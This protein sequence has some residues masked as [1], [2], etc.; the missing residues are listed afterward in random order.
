MFG[1][2]ASGTVQGSM[3]KFG[4]APLPGEVVVGFYRGTLEGV[5]I[6][7]VHGENPLASRILNEPS[8]YAPEVLG[9]KFA[10]FALAMREYTRHLLTPGA[11]PDETLPDGVHI[12]D[13][14]PLPAFLCIR[15]A[16]LDAGRDVRSLITMHLLTW[17]RR[18][19]D[20]LLACGVRDTPMTFHI[21]GGLQTRSLR[22]VYEMCRSGGEEPTLERLGCVV[23]DKV[24]SVSQNYIQSDIIP[25]CGG[26]MIA[27]KTDYTWNGCDW[28]FGEMR[29]SVLRA[30]P[31]EVITVAPERTPSWVIRNH[32]LTKAL[33]EIPADGILIDN[34]ASR[35][36]IAEEFHSLPYHSD[37]RVD[38]F[39]A[40]G[41]LVLCTGRVSYQKGIEHIFASLPGV[42]ERVPNAR[43]VFFLVPT[44]YSVDDLRRYMWEARKYPRNVRMVFGVV[45]S[46]YWMAHLAAD[47]YCCP[48]RWEPFGIVA[49]EAMSARVPVVATYVGGLMESILHLEDDPAMGTGLLLP[50]GDEDALKWA[51]VSLLSAQLIQECTENG[52][53]VDPSLL[54]NIAHPRLRR[55]V[56]AN[57]AF[58]E[59]IR[60][61][62]LARMNSTFRWRTVSERLKHLYLQL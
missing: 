27:G 15:Q 13:H 5:P 57:P 34:E 20:F 62:C 14:H 47:V 38:A 59:V 39:D 7:L 60:S 9:A 17:P 55:A 61:N 3:A 25:H 29:A 2:G 21:W 4:M 33:G 50:N 40:D 6:L 53:P 28:D 46:V 1:L 16:L 49:L 12:H 26:D 35:H 18:S 48:S 31:P 8:V 54:G 37:G 45:K 11:S 24:V 19:F 22:E 44:P 58:S 42:L 52:D 23:A 51:L 36:A 10:V 30:L 32:F 56:E 43:F 41:P